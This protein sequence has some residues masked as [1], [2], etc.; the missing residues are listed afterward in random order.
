M[1]INKIER[2]KKQGHPHFLVKLFMFLFILFLLDFAIGSILKSLYF[3]Q[4]SGLLYRTT[5]AL[6]STKADI[7]IFGASKA[8]HHYYPD[9]F[10]KKLNMSC[11]NAGRDGYDIFYHYAILQGVLKRYSP[12]IVI[13][14]F[15]RVEFFRNQDSYDR[16]SS[17]LPYYNEHPEM[18]SIIQL[19]SPYE[20][21]KLLSKIYPYNSLIFTIAM[22]NT[23]F[24]KSRRNNN[25]DNGYVPLTK[26]WKER[27]ITDTSFKKY[28]LDSNKIKLFKSFVMDCINSNVKLYIFISPYFKNFKFEDPSVLIAEEFTKKYNIPF[29]DFSNDSLFLNHAGLFYD[30]IHLNDRGAKIYSN[31]VIDKIMQDQLNNESPA[32][33]GSLLP[34]NNYSIIKKK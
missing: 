11:Y 9:A 20:K 26:I 5:Y 32:I 14:D 27:I 18:R 10:E 30:P 23:R 7:L 12:K 22:G 31:I 29:Y 33:K 16:L 28:E 1:K 17:L 3:T 19:K 15:A 6:D 13:L 24:N 25:D 21:Y 8:N 2:I 4:D 34:L